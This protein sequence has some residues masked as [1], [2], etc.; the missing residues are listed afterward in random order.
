MWIKS[1]HACP[2]AIRAHGRTVDWT[3]A[4][5]YLAECFSAQCVEGA[6]RGIPKAIAELKRKR[7]ERNILDGEHEALDWIPSSMFPLF[8][9][10]LQEGANDV[11]VPLK[12]FKAEKE[13]DDRITADD[14]SFE[15]LFWAAILCNRTEV[16][17]ALIALEFKPGPLHIRCALVK[18]EDSHVEEYIDCSDD[19]AEDA[20]DLF[21]L[22]CALKKPLAA[23]ALMKK[24]R[25]NDKD[26]DPNEADLVGVLRS[27]PPKLNADVDVKKNLVS[28]IHK[29]RV[30]TPQDIDYTL[31]LAANFD[32]EVTS[33]RSSFYVS[34]E[35]LRSHES[36]HD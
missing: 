15:C 34:S 19:I 36:Q 32:N 35:I 1:G 26:M 22:A 6:Q 31:C 20:A 7:E 14:P 33:V 8:L 4:Q 10:I 9:A 27:D 11:D 16:C 17:D 25:E 18:T 12:A 2:N 5:V 23:T 28:M 30:L 24:L 29:L 13:L 3:N 21:H